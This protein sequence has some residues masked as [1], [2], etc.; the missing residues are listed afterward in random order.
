MNERDLRTYLKL[1][2][3]L[4]R[5]GI[6]RGCVHVGMTLN[7]AIMVIRELECS[8]NFWKDQYDQLADTSYSQGE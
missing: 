5:F 8:R 1:K 4:K 7:D 6:D 2:E 3:D